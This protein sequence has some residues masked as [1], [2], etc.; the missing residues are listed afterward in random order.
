MKDHKPVGRK[1]RRA[2]DS[3]LFQDDY[4]PDLSHACGWQRPERHGFQTLGA[5]GG[6]T[7]TARL[8][9]GAI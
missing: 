5:Q 3:V 2:E 7:P 4:A 8:K 1:S 6:G 9:S